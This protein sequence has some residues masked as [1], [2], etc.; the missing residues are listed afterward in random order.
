MQKV[1]AVVVGNLDTITGA[2]NVAAQVNA[3]GQFDAVIHNAAVGFRDQ[4]RVTGTAFPISRGQ[5][6]AASYI[7][8]A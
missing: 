3:M 7:A 8:P 1:E 4:K 2:K 6:T 5:R